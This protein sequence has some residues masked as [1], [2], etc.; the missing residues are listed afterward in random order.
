M[1]KGD[2]RELE[3]RLKFWLITRLGGLVIAVAGLASTIV[4]FW[5]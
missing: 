4:H 5:R 3:E 2:L 1:T